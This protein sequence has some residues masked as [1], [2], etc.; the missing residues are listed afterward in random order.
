MTSYS[1]NAYDVAN[2]FGCFEKI[3]DYTVFLP[4]FT[5]VRH[6]MA[7]LI[8]GLFAPFQYRGSSKIGLMYE[9]CHS[10]YSVSEKLTNF[11]ENYLNVQ[12]SESEFLTQGY[13]IRNWNSQI[14]K[15]LQKIF[16]KIVF[17]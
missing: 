4:S 3:L 12:G 10:K 2:F 7:E 6:Q 16:F 1:D 15:V 9:G 14:R 11:G 13:G 17:K 5:V 8:W